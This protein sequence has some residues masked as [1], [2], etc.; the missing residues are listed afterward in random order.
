MMP[1]Q[2]PIARD[3][4]RAALSSAICLVAFTLAACVAD[5]PVGVGPEGVERTVRPNVSASASL[6]NRHIV[7]L[8]DS[9]RDSKAVAIALAKAW[10]GE[11][12]FAYETIKGFAVTLPDGAAE[13]LRR[14]PRVAAIEADRI[15]AAADV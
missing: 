14:N 7:T 8:D 4:L 5:S 3:P 9:V 11:L 6:A 15:I 1:C 2:Q 13:A 10:R 12:H